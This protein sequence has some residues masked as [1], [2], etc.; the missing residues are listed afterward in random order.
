LEG[1]SSLQS[2][3]FE[4]AACI[5]VVLAERLQLKNKRQVGEAEIFKDVEEVTVVVK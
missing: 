2:F 5:F 3:V 4:E 1:E